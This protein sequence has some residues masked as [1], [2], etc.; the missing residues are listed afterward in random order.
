MAAR[1]HIDGED[2]IA[3]WLLD[4]EQ[5]LEVGLLPEHVVHVGVVQALVLAALE[6]NQQV[7]RIELRPGS[8][9]LRMAF[10]ARSLLSLKRVMGT[11]WPDPIW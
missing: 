11:A 5:V 3:A 2:A 7:A 8:S 4:P 9:S 6:E 10:T 1:L